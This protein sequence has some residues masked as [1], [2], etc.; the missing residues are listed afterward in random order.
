M[1]SIITITSEAITLEALLAEMGEHPCC[2]ARVLFLG[3]VRREN[4]KKSVQAI[5]Y[6]CYET[7]AKK[8]LQTIIHEAKK[9][10]E[11]HEI[12]VAHRIGHLS[13]GQVSLIVA[14]FSPHRKAAFL[15][16]EYVI[17]QLKKKV[18]IFKREIYATGE[19]AWLA[20]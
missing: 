16:G 9:L 5:F 12:G 4:E 19:A 2:G 8:E 3:T 13:V 17:D 10:W 14:V 15:A 20:K 18:P 6:E 7:M 1:D 11:V